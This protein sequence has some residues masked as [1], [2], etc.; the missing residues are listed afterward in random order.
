MRRRGGRRR[1]L[2]ALKMNDN[3]PFELDNILLETGPADQDFTSL[4]VD[5]VAIKNYDNRGNLVGTIEH[6][7]LSCLD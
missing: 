7:P 1:D 2:R 5:A 3:N 6:T 4:S